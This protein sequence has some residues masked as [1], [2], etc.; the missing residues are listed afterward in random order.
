MHKTKCSS[1]IHSHLQC[2]LLMHLLISG[3]QCVLKTPDDWMLWSRN[4]ACSWSR[5]VWPWAGEGRRCRLASLSVHGGSNSHYVS[6]KIDWERWDLCSAIQLLLTLKRWTWWLCFP[7]KP[8]FHPHL[9]VSSWILGF[10]NPLLVCF[11]TPLY[12][13]LLYTQCVANNSDHQPVLTF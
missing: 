10:C 1:I 11:N 5:H 2:A 12:H 9:R 7:R 8:V 4:A 6:L 3:F 13:R